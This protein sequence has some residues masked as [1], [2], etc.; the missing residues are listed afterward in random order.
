MRRNCYR[1]AS[2]ASSSL[3]PSSARKCLKRNKVSGAVRY[4]NCCRVI[5]T[6][7]FRCRAGSAGCANTGGASNPNAC[8]AGDADARSARCALHA[9]CPRSSRWSS[10]RADVAPL[11]AGPH[12]TVT[13]KCAGR[14]VRIEQRGGTNN[15]YCANNRCAVGR[16][17]IRNALDKYAN[18]SCAGISNSSDRAGCASCASQPRGACFADRAYRALRSGGTRLPLNALRTSSA[19]RAFWPVNTLN[20]L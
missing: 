10:D 17:C 12:K 2:S 3:R 14:R 20:T 16:P 11:S 4:F 15:P 7:H 19:R 13:G 8:R 5:R 6:A 9:C 18:A 1:R